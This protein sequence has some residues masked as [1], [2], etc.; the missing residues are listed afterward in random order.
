MCHT[1]K[2]H[3]NVDTKVHIVIA[4]KNDNYHLILNLL[5]NREKIKRTLNI[6][7]STNRKLNNNSKGQY[8]LTG[9]NFYVQNDPHIPAGWTVISF[10]QDQ[11]EVVHDDYAH[12][13]NS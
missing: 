13:S 8:I 2:L 3:Y 9:Q 11:L 1:N 5:F 4:L 6:R 12:K 7:I 10:H